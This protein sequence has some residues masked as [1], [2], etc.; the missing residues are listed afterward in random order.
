MINEY[1]QEDIEKCRKTIA[2][3]EHY[4]AKYRITIPPNV[5]DFMRVITRN[6]RRDLVR[7]MVRVAKRKAAA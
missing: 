2:K 5:Y 1:T 6:E 7:Y 4:Q 3:R